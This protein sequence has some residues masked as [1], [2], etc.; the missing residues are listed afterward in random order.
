MTLMTPEQARQRLSLGRN[1]IYSLLRS[2]SIR[3]VRV[4]RAIRISDAEIERFISQG[5]VAG[6]VHRG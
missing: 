3:A 1:T 4:G 5:G 2:G 6:P